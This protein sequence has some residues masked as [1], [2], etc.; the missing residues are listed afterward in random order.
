MKIELNTKYATRDGN[1]YGIVIGFNRRGRGYGHVYEKE[2]RK[3][4]DQN[5][6]WDRDGTNADGLTNFDLVGPGFPA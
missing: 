2:T 6:D 3:C 1:H 4:V 5:G